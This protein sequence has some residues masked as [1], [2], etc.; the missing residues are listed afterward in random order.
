MMIASRVQ[1]DGAATSIVQQF[2]KRRGGG[3]WREMARNPEEGPRASGGRWSP[4]YS[5]SPYC[6]VTTCTRT[7]HA[8]HEVTPATRKELCDEI[9]ELHSAAR[10]PAESE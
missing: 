1:E 9:A 8:S 2:Q 7:S 3:M 5:H 4:A 10:V 6:L